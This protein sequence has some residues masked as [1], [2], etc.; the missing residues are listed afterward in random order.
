MFNKPVNLET[1]DFT[2]TV[3][4][5]LM[6][7]YVLGN[8]LKLDA[9]GLGKIIVQCTKEGVGGNLQIKAPISN[10]TLI[11][12]NSSNGD[13]VVEKNVIIDAT[14][15]IGSVGVSFNEVRI[16]DLKNTHKMIQ[17]ESNT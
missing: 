6:Y 5:N 12:A 17:L 10:V 14:N 4:G 15:S 7:D 1:N 13:I 16:V 8:S 3:N 2:L 11:G 9:G